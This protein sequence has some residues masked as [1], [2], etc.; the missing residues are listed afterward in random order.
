MKTEDLGNSKFLNWLLKP[1]GR[2]MESGLRH[3]F[4][5]PVKILRG[6]DIRP[7]Q[8]VLAVIP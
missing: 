2:A 1:A 5:D 8:T 3:R 6:A 4:S 7:G